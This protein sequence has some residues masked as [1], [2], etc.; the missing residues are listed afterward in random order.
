MQEQYDYSKFE[1]WLLLKKY[2]PATVGTTIRVVEYFRT[3]A[4]TES[5]S[6]LAGVSYSDAMLFIRWSSKH[7]ASQKTIGNYLGHIRKFYQF[8]ISEREIKENPV[9]HIRMQ[10]IKRKIYHDI[11][12]TG[13]LQMLYNRYPTT[14]VHEA[15]KIIPPQQNN[16]FSRKRN[17]VILSL[18]VHQGLRV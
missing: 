18:L 4:Q 14:I 5:V 2:S 9:A 15:G 6:D 11:L 3:W 1:E 10:G 16:I 8:L 7:G 13:E 12:S 17:K